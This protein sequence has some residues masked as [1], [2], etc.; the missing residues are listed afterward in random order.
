[1]EEEPSKE[2]C[3]ENPQVFVLDPLTKNSTINARR[4]LRKQFQEAK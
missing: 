3:S 4:S 2:Q 1:M